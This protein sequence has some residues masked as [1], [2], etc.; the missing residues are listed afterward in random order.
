MVANLCQRRIR[1]GSVKLFT[2]QA[3][4]GENIIHIPK[5]ASKAAYSR[6]A[7]KNLQEHLQTS[8]LLIIQHDGFVLNPDAWDDEFLQ[9]D[10]IGAPWFYPDEFNVGNGGFSLRSKRLLIA[11]QNE[12]VS[13]LHPEDW[14]IGRTYRRFLEGQGIRFAP[15]S[16]ARRFSIEGNTKYGWKWSGQFGFHSYFATDLSKWNVFEH[17]Q[18]VAD[19]RFILS[20][21][22][23]RSLLKIPQIVREWTWIQMLFGK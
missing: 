1:F 8:H 4:S 12:H 22:A 10:Y 11:L 7:L 16:V 13:Q 3:V 23:K 17:A 9:Y 5:I 21:L 14:V 6:F 15:E 20:Y 18:L 2:S 19:R